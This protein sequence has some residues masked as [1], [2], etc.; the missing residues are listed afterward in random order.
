MA[1]KYEMLAAAQHNEG[2]LGRA[3]VDE[4]VFVLRAKD[5]AAAV[6]VRIWCQLGWHMAHHDKD[7]IDGALKIAD[8]MEA[9]RNEHC[10]PFRWSRD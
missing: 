2:C 9:W 10:E 6:I 1:T 7:Q 5:P 3:A 4:P 8:E